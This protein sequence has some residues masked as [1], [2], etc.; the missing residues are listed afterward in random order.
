MDDGNLISQ[1]YLNVADALSN[2]NNQVAVYDKIPDDWV[3]D[4]SLL[5]KNGEEVFS[6]PLSKK[7][8]EKIEQSKGINSSRV[9]SI[10]RNLLMESVGAFNEHNYSESER[11]KLYNELKQNYE[12]DNPEMQKRLDNIMRN[13]LHGMS[14][15]EGKDKADDYLYFIADD[16]RINAGCHPGKIVRVNKGLLN[17]YSSDDEIASLL[18]HELAHGEKRH[19]HNEKNILIGANSFGFGSN[20]GNTSKLSVFLSAVDLSLGTKARGDEKEADYNGFKY[21]LASGYNVG[22]APAFHSHSLEYGYVRKID[23]DIKKLGVN[24]WNY[25]KNDH[26][27]GDE[28]INSYLKHI[29]DYSNGMITFDSNTHTVKINGKDFI[30]PTRTIDM[31]ADERAYFVMGALA[32]IYH[33]GRQNEPISIKDN[34]L[35]IGKEEIFKC[36]KDDISPQILSSRLNR[37]REELNLEN[38]DMHSYI[39]VSNEK[40]FDKNSNNRDN[41]YEYM[42]NYDSDGNVFSKGNIESKKARQTVLDFS[43]DMSS[44]LHDVNSIDLNGSKE[45]IGHQLGKNIVTFL[46]NSSTMKFSES[47]RQQYNENLD[48]E[49]NFAKTKFDNLYKELNKTKEEASKEVKDWNRD[50]KKA[51]KNHDDELLRDLY[52]SSP[53]DVAYKVDKQREELT[54]QVRIAN[55]PIYNK[56]GLGYGR[57]GLSYI[58][59]NINT[60]SNSASINENFKERNAKVLSL[61]YDPT[62]Q[63]AI[64]DEVSKDSEALKNLDKLDIIDNRLRQKYTEVKTNIV[65]EEVS[66]YNHKTMMNR[67]SSCKNTLN[68]FLNNSFS[69]GDLIVELNNRDSNLK[70]ELMQFYRYKVFLLRDIENNPK[71]R[72]EN[73]K[74]LKQFVDAEKEIYQTQ[75]FQAGKLLLNEIPGVAKIET[76][77][78]QLCKEAGMGETL[79]K[80][81]S[82]SSLN[83]FDMSHQNDNQTRKKRT[84]GLI[85]NRLE[86]NFSNERN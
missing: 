54:K 30:K 21:L 6:I 44:I 62:V 55:H 39:M 20:D 43:K 4:V 3:R 17:S 14:V 83:K 33:D 49:L 66:I 8:M 51:Q 13:V 7:L 31:N 67:I 9:F 56:L 16:D 65:S 41:T 28:R 57:N 73:V 36:E 18:C 23:E 60:H 22:A 53:S 71:N 29:S 84:N 26:P 68:R 85:P 70:S 81:F 25:N 24:D 35:F 64:L 78:N 5:D 45:E 58:Y 37:I 69:K 72:V 38:R 10:G 77:T 12:Y 50:Y 52:E 48:A 59:K 75:K 86:P 46:K 15:I 74:N 11:L 82:L 34:S 63:K 32:K 19:I 76:K 79:L 2:D 1:E 80:H 27:L 47:L 42:L 40:N 61:L